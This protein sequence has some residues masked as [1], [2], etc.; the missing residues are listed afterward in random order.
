MPACTVILPG[1]CTVMLPPSIVMFAPPAVDRRMLFAAAQSM[2]AAALTIL[3]SSRACTLSTSACASNSMACLAAISC[4]PILFSPALT[5]P[6]SAPMAWPLCTR[7]WPPPTNWVSWPLIREVVS[8]FANWMSWPASTPRPARA[9]MAMMASLLC[10]SLSS[11][12]LVGLPAA[13][14]RAA[15]VLSW[16][17]M[18]EAVVR[19]ACRGAAF[20]SS[21]LVFALAGPKWLAYATVL[22]VTAAALKVS[23]SLAACLSKTM[24]GALSPAGSRACASWLTR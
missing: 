1:H 13:S 20:S 21:T 22:C 2:C 14:R 6:A 4:R 8:P 23:P 12:G 11:P 19:K 5:T 15:A 9:A 10:G 18:P 17:S 7:N 3:T 16:L 24:P